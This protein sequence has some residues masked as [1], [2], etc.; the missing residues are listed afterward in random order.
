MNNKP[1]QKRFALGSVASAKSPRFDSYATME[2]LIASDQE[3][4]DLEEKQR[5]DSRAYDQMV[6]DNEVPPRDREISKE[7]VE[8]LDDART[9]E[10]AKVAASVKEPDPAPVADGASP[11]VEFVGEVQDRPQEVHVIA[12]E[13]EAEEPGEELD[14]EAAEP[15]E[16]V[17]STNRPGF[18]DRAKGWT[19]QLW[20]ETR[21]AN[22]RIAQSRPIQTGRAVGKKAARR[23]LNF[24]AAIPGYFLMACFAAMA[25]VDVIGLAL[26]DSALGATAVLVALI[27]GLAAGNTLLAGAAIILSMVAVGLHLIRWARRQRPGRN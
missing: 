7:I 20:A 16:S 2:D 27:G 9:R 6:E 5:E 19:R 12:A 24:L 23:T 17:D 26:L 15:A 25:F 1:K 3:A 4:R 21:Q 11:E 13:A 14:E 22:S 18:A 10:V 8:S